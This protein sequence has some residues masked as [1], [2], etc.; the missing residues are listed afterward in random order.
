MS[1][2]FPGT[3]MLSGSNSSW[4]IA[5]FPFSGPFEG[6]LKIVSEKVVLFLHLKKWHFTSPSAS[7]WSLSLNM[8]CLHWALPCQEWEFCSG[9]VFLAQVGVPWWIMWGFWTNCK[10][11]EWNNVVAIKH[12]APPRRG[13]W[14]PALLLC[15]PLPPRLAPSSQTSLKLDLC[16]RK[17]RIFPGL[18][19][20]LSP[21]KVG[22]PGTS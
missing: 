17:K 2:L 14:Q 18:S 22:A 6:D 3:K 9:R 8:L 15:S 7:R 16:P 19:L 1:Q 20:Q 11:E 10:Q 4:V 12:K 13:C 5:P 21:A